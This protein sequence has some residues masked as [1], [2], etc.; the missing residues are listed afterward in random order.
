MYIYKKNLLTKNE[1]VKIC[2]EFRAIYELKKEDTDEDIISY[3]NK[4][5]DYTKE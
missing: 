2:K 5:I 3:I 4:M 1:I